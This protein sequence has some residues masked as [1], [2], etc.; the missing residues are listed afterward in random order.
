MIDETSG[1]MNNMF[2]SFNIGPAHVIGFS[3]EFYYYTEYGLKQIHNQ[4]EW[5]ENDL[6]EANEPKNRAK[7]PWIITMAHRPMYCSTADDDDCTENESI[8]SI[9]YHCHIIIK[10]Y[11]KLRKGIPIVNAYGLEDLFYKYGVDIIFG[12]H[13]HV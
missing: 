13:E 8:V 2:Y 3:S 1:K 12:A 10:I 4:F 6:K 11:L 9:N 5:L 7:H